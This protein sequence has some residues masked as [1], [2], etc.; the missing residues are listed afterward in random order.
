MA[1]VRRAVHLLRPVRQAGRRAL[2]HPEAGDRRQ[3][4]GGSRDG[5]DGGVVERD[6][7]RHASAAQHD[8]PRRVADD[9][10]D[11]ALLPEGEPGRHQDRSVR[12]GQ[13]CVRPRGSSRQVSELMLMFRNV[14]NTKSVQVYSKAP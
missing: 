13:V 10:P 8:D 9:G 2:D 6:V 12:S 5:G 3:H 7:R 14:Y 4:A 11:A 1:S